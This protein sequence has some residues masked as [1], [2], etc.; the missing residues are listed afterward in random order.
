MTDRLL[1]VFDGSAWFV[2]R[3]RVIEHDLDLD[4]KVYRCDKHL[5]GPLTLEQ[6]RA[7]DDSAILVAPGSGHI[8]RIPL[9]GRFEYALLARFL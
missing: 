3:V 2:R 4:E 1:I 9:E 8:V 7:L 6:M 5:A